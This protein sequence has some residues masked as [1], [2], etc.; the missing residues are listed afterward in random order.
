MIDRC[1]PACG[2]GGIC[3]PSITNGTTARGTCR[4]QPGWGGVSCDECAEG[5][6][7]AE[8]QGAPSHSFTERHSSQPVP[9]TVRN[10]MMV[11]LGPAP[12][13]GQ[14]LIPSKVSRLPLHELMVGCNCLHGTCTSDDT[15]T[16]AAGWITDSTSGGLCD[17]CSPGFFQTKSGDCLGTL[18]P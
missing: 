14:L 10:V 4:C 3:A 9:E 15:C 8:C 2:S 13:W 11:S 1:E 17:T 16:C 6:W 7:G 5:H 12:A 18:T